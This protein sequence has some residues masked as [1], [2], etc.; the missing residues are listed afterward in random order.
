MGDGDEKTVGRYE[1]GERSDRDAP[2]ALSGHIP[3]VPR[4]NLQ[5]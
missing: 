4:L 1:P 2:L 3:T 5:P